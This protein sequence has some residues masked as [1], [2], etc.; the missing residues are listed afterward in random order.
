L[1][2]IGDKPSNQTAH[3]AKGQPL[4]RGP[5]GA[6]RSLA[7][8]GALDQ[9]PGMQQRLYGLAILVAPALVFACNDELVADV[10]QDVCLSEKQWIGGKRGSEEMY[11]GRDCVGCHLQNDGPE[12]IFGGTLYPFVEP[13]Y[14][15]Y[16][17][18]IDCFG[19]E[20]YTVTVTGSDGQVFEAETNAAG[21]FFFEGKQSDLVKPFRVKIDWFNEET[22]MI[23]SPQMARSPSYGGC[24]KCHNPS[25]NFADDYTG[26]DVPL[27]TIV[28]PTTYIGLG[29]LVNLPQV[30][31]A[32]E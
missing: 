2:R 29:G 8:G 21:N 16:Q 22:G 1:W 14:S 32:V 9:S 7:F 18:G 28:A 26:E 27:E 15:Q 13:Q 6:P 5:A 25:L 17:S 10:P 20:G 19:V 12:L 3:F 24:G 31:P 30:F 11:P 23:Q 4:G